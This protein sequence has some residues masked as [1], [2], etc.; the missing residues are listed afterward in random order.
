M[1]QPPRSVADGLR[2][3]R[4]LAADLTRELVRAGIHP[5]SASYSMA[6][7]IRDEANGLLV[8][9]DGPP[10]IDADQPV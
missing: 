3:I 8:T 2:D 4:D 5:G 1:S 6:A 10:V 7:L 9:V